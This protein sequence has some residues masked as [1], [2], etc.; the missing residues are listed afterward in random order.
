MGFGRHGRYSTSRRPERPRALLLCPY[1]LCDRDDGEMEV[2]VNGHAL[3]VCWAG[4][5]DYW[6][7]PLAAPGNT[8]RLAPFRSKRGDFQR[9]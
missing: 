6:R 5:R 8:C 1:L 4:D 3:R 9:P 2:V 7:D